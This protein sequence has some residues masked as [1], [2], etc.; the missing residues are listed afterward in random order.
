MRRQLL[1]VC[2]LAL[3]AC[4]EVG[5]PKLDARPLP[6]PEL[7]VVNKCPAET[8][9][10]TALHLHSAVDSYRGTKNH[11][12]APLAVEARTVLRPM[13]GRWFVTVIRTKLDSTPIAM[14]TK[15]PLELVSGSYELWVLQ[16]S[17]RLYPPKP[18]PAA[19]AGRDAARSDAPA[20]DLASARDLDAGAG[21]DRAAD[22]G[23]Q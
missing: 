2:L 13:A 12:A 17:F 5:P 10:F 19:D 22:R 21:P 23:G 11:L 1:I 3:A 16:Q 7:V 14:T 8:P 20:R 9:P 15:T 18:L 6:P 4:G